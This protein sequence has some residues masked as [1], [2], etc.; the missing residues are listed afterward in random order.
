MEELPECPVCLQNYD[1]ENAI[2]R[3][4]SCGHTVCEAC[5]VHLPPRF[6]NT[7]RC[8]AC[9]QLVK[10]SPN[11][12]PSSLPKN[13]DLLRISLQHSSSSHKSNQRSSINDEYVH[14]SK[15]W[16][17]EF[18]AAW[19]DWFLPHDTVSVTEDGVGRFNSN[20]KGRVCFGVN[21]TVSLAPI[22]T[23]SP[24]TDSKFKFSYVAWVIKCLEEMNEVV[25]EGL[26]FILEA[27]VRQSRLC[28]VYGLWSEVVGGSLYLVCERQ[29]GRVLEKFGGG[30]DLDKDGHFSFAM[31]AKSVIEPMIALNLEGLV[32]GCLGISCFCF[33]ELGGVCIDLNEVLAMG[34]KIMDQVS[35]GTGDEPS[36]K[37]MFTECLDLENEIF[38]S[39]EVLSMF[40]H[41]RIVNPESGDSRYPIGY[42]S[43][44]WS[45][46]CVLLQLLIGNELPRIT[47]EMSE[48]N[49]LDV[50]ASYISWVEKVSSVLE[51][52]IS[53][54]YLSLKQTLCKCLDI[55]PENR[56][57]VVDVRKSIQDLFVKH[58]FG[59]LG[60]SELTVNRNNTG[61]PV[62]LAKL[63]Q[64]LEESS[65]E[66]REH[67]LQ[68]KEDGGQPDILQGAKNISDED[69]TASISQGMI[70]LKDLQGHLGCITGLAVGGMNSEFI[71]KHC[72]LYQ[73]YFMI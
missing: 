70:E 32:A 34:R 16:S 73:S 39:P 51:E 5:L 18:Y 22:I 69:F 23:L 17:H 35:G 72:Y 49:G 20:S 62:I 12:G 64:L 63:C 29:C 55:N 47:F 4:L 11:Q 58:Q 9:T 48:G 53:S 7:I 3:V 65:K 71:F 37:S 66:P 68:A 54:E 50:S 60:D 28:R 38:V 14:S 42:G 21:R 56:P 52:K 43:D 57:D 46:A 59:F 15:F 31:I 2:P 36:H 44:V 1:D 13:I 8:P 19:K 27:S 61:H 10:Y 45:L 6:P 24:V 25:R 67:G 30:L 40:L 33:D 41:K 26:G